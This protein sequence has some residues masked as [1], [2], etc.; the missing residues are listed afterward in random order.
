VNQIEIDRALRKLRL[1]GIADVLEVRVRGAQAERQPHLDFLSTLVSDELTRRQDRLLGRRIKLAGFRDSGKT[2]DAFDLDFN[3]KMN[4]QLI[5]ELAT[6]RFVERR[7]DVLLLGP[8]GTGKSHLAHAIGH[9][10]IQQGHKVRYREAHVLI[11]ELA[12]ANLDGRRKEVMAALAAVPLLIV[13]DLGMRKLPATAAEDLLELVMRRYERGATLLT[14]NRPV[15]DWGKL[16]GDNAA[17][18]ALLD[19]LLHHA[20]VMQCGPKSWRTHHA[21]S[22]RKDA[23]SR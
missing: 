8:P 9:A 16:L 5:Y 6:A 20:H 12:D 10:A 23:D 11:E 1:S 19:R 21:A 7:E 15:E 18:T 2:L 17:V 14:S 4:R 22:L 3:K 13:D